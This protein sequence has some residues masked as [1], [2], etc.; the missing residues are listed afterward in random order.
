[1]DTTVPHGLHMIVDATVP[2]GWLTIVAALVEFAGI[3]LPPF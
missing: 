3:F 1:M 2:G